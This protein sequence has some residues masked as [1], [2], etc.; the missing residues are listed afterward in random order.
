M[1]TRRFGRYRFESSKEDKVLFPDAGITKGD[2]IDYYAAVAPVM[3]PHVRDRPI[4]MQRWPDGID[5]HSFFQKET[6]DYFPDWIKSVKVDTDE[7]AQEQVMCQNQATLAYLAQQA[8]ITPHIWLSRQDKLDYPDL[9]V[10]DLDPPG[11][12]FGPV[13]LAAQRC[14]QAVEELGLTAHIQLTGSRGVHI[15]CPLDR[16]ADFDS[17]KAVAR[18]LVGVLAQRYPQ[19]M[20]IEHRKAKRRG[21]VYLDVARNNYGQTIVPPYAVRAR[22]GAPVAAPITWDELDDA[23]LDSQHYTI[24][25]IRR[26]LG[27]RDCPWKDIRKHAQSIAKLLER[28]RKVTDRK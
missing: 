19:D 17:V 11:R 7:G 27:Q 23:G 15:A 9:L 22:P 13:R 6:P 4:S 5:K 1:P 18:A 12:E 2:L 20:T 3:L 21:R 14:R 24:K 8:C 10:L 25:T 16:S 28:V 26:R